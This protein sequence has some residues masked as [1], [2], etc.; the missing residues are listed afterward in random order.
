M[1]PGVVKGAYARLP[2]YFKDTNRVVMVTMPQKDGLVPPTEAD[3]KEAMA[4]AAKAA[5]Q[6]GLNPDRPPHWG[7][8]RLVPDRYEFWQGRRSRLHDR[9]RDRLERSRCHGDCADRRREQ[10]SDDGTKKATPVSGSHDVAGCPDETKRGTNAASKGGIVGLTLPVARE[11]APIGIRVV[12]ISP[13][14]IDTPMTKV[15]RYPM[16]FLMPAPRFAR[17]AADVIRSGRSYAVIPWQMRGVSWLLRLLD[18]I[19][20]VIT[21][22]TTAVKALFA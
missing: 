10:R 11:F 21:A 2:K 17:L 8:Y 22:T 19:N 1:G 20:V 13:G 6:H 16:P 15:N 14:Y 18:G 12:T 9:L 4:N 5:V 7:G 3:L